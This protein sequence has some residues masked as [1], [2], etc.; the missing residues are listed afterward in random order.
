M[1]KHVAYAWH[2]CGR[3][4]FHVDLPPSIFPVEVE[5]DPPII[6][7]PLKNR[8]ANVG[9]AR[10]VCIPTQERGNEGYIIFSVAISSL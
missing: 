1:E 3:V 5:L 6:A 8:R 4:D 9:I 2:C 10:T 7:R